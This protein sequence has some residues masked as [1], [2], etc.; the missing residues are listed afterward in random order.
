MK[1]LVEKVGKD[2]AKRCVNQIKDQ[3]KDNLKDQAK[4]D[5]KDFINGNKQPPPV[6]ASIPDPPAPDG[7]DVS[8]LKIDVNGGQFVLAENYFKALHGAFITSRQSQPSLSLCC[9]Y[10]Y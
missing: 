7:V 10:G 8:N 9:T 5:L 2:A 3:V 6:P 4:Q 1:K